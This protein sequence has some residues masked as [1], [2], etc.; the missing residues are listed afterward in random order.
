MAINDEQPGGYRPSSRPFDV[1]DWYK[2]TASGHTPAERAAHSL[3]QS[4][5][6][7]HGNY[8]EHI[9]PLQSKMTP[10]GYS[11]HSKPSVPP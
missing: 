10:E 8:I 9:A 5:L 6:V 1:P 4:A 11:K 3:L 2:A 7:Q